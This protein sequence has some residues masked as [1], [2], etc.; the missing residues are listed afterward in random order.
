MHH[1]SVNTQTFG[2]TLNRR[3]SEANA[4]IVKVMGVNFGIHV[5]D[6]IKIPVSVDLNGQ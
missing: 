2:A 3:D 4:T 6:Y 1:P 5:H